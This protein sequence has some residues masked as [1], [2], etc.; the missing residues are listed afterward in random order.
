MRPGLVPGVNVDRVNVAAGMRRA[1]EVGY[2]DATA[3]MVAEYALRRHARGEED[4][5]ER[6]WL[7]QYPRDLTSWRIALAH[8]LAEAGLASDETR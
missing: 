2:S 1:A 8:A 4:G 5:A 7:R 6:T 3:Q